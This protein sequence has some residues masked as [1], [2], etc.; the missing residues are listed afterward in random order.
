MHKINND[1]NITGID[2]FQGLPKELVPEIFHFLTM[3]ELFKV[4]PV[5]KLFA[6]I[7]REEQDRRF[8]ELYRQMDQIGTIAVENKDNDPKRKTEPTTTVQIKEWQA[9]RPRSKQMQ[10]LVCCLFSARQ[11]MKLKFGININEYNKICQQ[12]LKTEAGCINHIKTN[13]KTGI[14][15]LLSPNKVRIIEPIFLL[16]LFLKYHPENVSDT[17]SFLKKIFTNKTPISTELIQWAKKKHLADIKRDF[18]TLFTET[19]LQRSENLHFLMDCGGVLSFKQLE[20][21][22]NGYDDTVMQQ[23]INNKQLPRGPFGAETFLLLLLQ[24]KEASKEVIQWCINSYK[25]G[26]I[27]DDKLFSFRLSEDKV[28]ML[29]E[30]RIFPLTDQTKQSVIS[31]LDPKKERERKILQELIQHLSNMDE[32]ILFTFIQQVKKIDSELL[33]LCLKRAVKEKIVIW[34]QGRTLF[35]FFNSEHFEQLY[36]EN[37]DAA[38]PKVI[39]SRIRLLMQ[40]QI[41]LQFPWLARS[42]RMPLLCFAI[43]KGCSFDLIQELIEWTP[44]LNEPGIDELYRVMEEIKGKPNYLQIK[45]ALIK[46]GVALDDEI[47][48]DGISDDG[49]YIDEHNPDLIISHIESKNEEQC[50]L[51]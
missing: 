27:I 3:E 1:S 19:S 28:I 10:K 47:F 41:T 7:S 49:I 39:E 21:F 44:H 38:A 24:E 33:F 13:A 30:N 32:T 48:F 18:N 50:N 15:F 43:R 8:N 20:D 37:S 12:S 9:N 11:A 2:Y 14:G 45:Q 35:H 46:K 25:E 40:V 6:R 17:Q 31:R 34:E 16:E 36:L 29:L 26:I 23:L 4:A 42:Q 22:L 5:C 51:S